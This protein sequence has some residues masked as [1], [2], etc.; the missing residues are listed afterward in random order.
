[1]KDL[2]FDVPATQQVRVDERT[3]AAIRKGIEDADQGRTVSLD[4]AQALIPQWISKFESQK[5]R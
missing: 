3:S 4:E 5:P 2:K 1:M